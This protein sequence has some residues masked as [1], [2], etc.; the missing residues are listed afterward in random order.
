MPENRVDALGLGFAVYFASGR[1]MGPG[2]AASLL[3]LFAGAAL[4]RDRRH[5]VEPGR[6]VPARILLGAP[7][8]HIARRRILSFGLEHLGCLA[9]HT[10]IV[11]LLAM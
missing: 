5:R 11:D 1:R 9:E 8:L 10:A 3:A 6:L 2:I 4:L 7:A